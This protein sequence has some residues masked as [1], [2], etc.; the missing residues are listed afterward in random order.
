MN[1]W[2]QVGPSFDDQPVFSFSDN[3]HLCSSKKYPHKNMPDKWDFPWTA[4]AW[5]L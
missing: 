2:S 3:P 5:P 1:M 4:T